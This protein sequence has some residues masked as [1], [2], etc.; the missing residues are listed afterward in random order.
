MP[1]SKA[2]FTIDSV[3]GIDSSGASEYDVTADGQRFLVNMVVAEA[4][5]LPITVVVNWTAA[6]KP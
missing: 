1:A 5:T 2:L 4:R 6:L 3:L